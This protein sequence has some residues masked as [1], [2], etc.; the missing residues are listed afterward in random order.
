MVVLLIAQAVLAVAFFADDSWK[1][2]LPHDDTGEAKKV[3]ADLDMLQAL[4][5]ITGKIQGVVA[6]ADG[7]IPAA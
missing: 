5:Q 4:H 1:K 6:Y 2:H 7:Q 3:W